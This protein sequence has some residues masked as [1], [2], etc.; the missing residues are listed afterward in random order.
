MESNHDI[1]NEID[2]AFD[3]Q[4]ELIDYLRPHLEGEAVQ[5]IIGGGNKYQKIGD[6]I[7]VEES[8]LAPLIDQAGGVEGS[9]FL[10][11]RIGQTRLFLSSIKNFNA[12][13]LLSLP[14][15]VESPSHEKTFTEKIALL[16]RLFE[17]ERKLAEEK[18]L[19]GIQKIQMRRQVKVL[20]IKNQEILEE[21][22]RNYQIIQ[23]HQEE[24]ADKL[25][26]EIEARTKELR[27]VN[28]K[29]KEI[30]RLQKKTLDVAATAII[31]LDMNQKIVNVNDEFCLITRY[32]KEE[33]IGRDYR[34]LLTPAPG[35]EKAGSGQEMQGPL[36]KSQGIYYTKDGRKLT[37]IRNADTLYD[38]MKQPAGRIESFVDV[39]DLIA[40]REKA[41]Y[42][43]IAK[44][45]FLANMSHEIRTPINAI[46]GM[47]E[48]MMETSLDAE[49][50][51]LLHTINTESIA[52]LSIIND[53]LDFSKIEAGKLALE[54]IPFDIRTLVEDLAG[55]MAIRSEQKGV[56][57]FSY[58][59]PGQKTLVLG[60]PG[61]L[62]QILM[63]L[64]GNALKFT[65]E[66]EIVIQ[67]RIAEEQESAVKIYFEVKDTGIGIPKSQQNR[68]FESFTQADGSTTRKYG[69]TGLGTTISKQLTE[70][71]G[72]EIGLESDE[73]K[74][75]T[76][77]FTVLF[78]K[79]NESDAG[80][81]DSTSPPAP[82]LPLRVEPVQALII[83]GNETGRRVVSDYLKS[84]GWEP[85]GL[86]TPGAACRFIEQHE[87]SEVHPSLIFV[88]MAM[89][90]DEALRKS[91][92]RISR[93][94]GTAVIIQKP[95]GPSN[96]APFEPMPRVT[97]YLTRPVRLSTLRNTV[98][99]LLSGKSF[100]EPE[101][102]LTLETETA[103][104]PREEEN[105]TRGAILLVEDYPAN[106]A[107]IQ[108]FLSG[109]G[110]HVELAENGAQAVE[111]FKKHP[112]DLIFMDMQMP[113]MD[114]YD[115][116]RTI[117]NLEKEEARSAIPIV[118]MT[119]NALPEDR[120]KCIEAGANDYVAKPLRKKQILH[121]VDTWIS[122]SRKSEG[123]TLEKTPA[124]TPSP[125]AD[126]PIKDEM[127][128]IAEA[129]I[130]LVEDN[131]SNQKVA[132]RHLQSLGCEVD[133]AENGKEAVQ[134]YLNN[135]YSLILM[136]VQMPVMDGYQATA[137]IRQLEQKQ[138]QNNR[139][140]K[141]PRTPI[142]AATANALEGDKEK[143]VAA[144]MDGYLSK[145]IKKKEI[146]ELL[147]TWVTFPSRKRETPQVSQEPCPM[148]FREALAEFNGDQIILERILNN[149]IHHIETRLP[150]MQ[151]A[152]QEKESVLLVREAH[153]IKGAAS[154]LMADDLTQAALCLEENGRNADWEACNTLLT[155]LTT[156]F[157]RLA[158]F[159]QSLPTHQP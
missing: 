88:D 100:S 29:L 67:A 129:R 151:R 84:F 153:S 137:I 39:T 61:R 7:P 91:L 115:A 80:Q 113:V 132:L 1:F 148:R 130:L 147:E 48:I 122:V 155:I 138:E 127:A 86:G 57:I 53:I 118:A 144:G 40:A 97:A 152:I 65:H 73:G 134:A 25:K 119:A 99:T 60:D 112:Y 121:A 52:L 69:G 90:A 124:E 21:N 28:D 54:T 83:D 34:I 44:S 62:R 116:I 108:T 114:G 128:G 131:K 110:C 125:P 157:Q 41:E 3:T 27:F 107:I 143:C 5:I 159:V 95:G 98:E 74:G 102:Q 24:Y 32:Q 16:I 30:S 68:I 141:P 117:R 37:V 101:K 17:S 92:N 13:L 76:F 31:T 46:L 4:R 94:P 103:L 120:G 142:I 105:K 23:K 51:D 133:L 140:E 158:L 85:T 9:P 42:A 45:E 111:A 81:T 78:G 87:P 59:P 77:W 50:T 11:H 20:E 150:V 109:Y 139:F 75:S 104:R 149:F 26:S 136:D 135:I 8:A 145:P 19:I 36:Y 70:L 156:E 2:E 47:A 49:Q 15:S 106:Q 12:L 123:A 35:D 56:K 126:E 72:G 79:A 71:M 10:L 63:N 22:H 93:A 14:S 89:M 55:G 146:Q 58:I 64:S 33:I 82:K 43:N 18:E 96:A 6:D 66:G 154:N 38:K